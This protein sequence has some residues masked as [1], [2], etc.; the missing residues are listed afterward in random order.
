MSEIAPEKLWEHILCNLQ[1]QLQMVALEQA[2][3]V[4]NV[5]FVGAELHLETADRDA[6]EF[7]SADV[8]ARRIII[9]ARPLLEIFAVKVKLVEEE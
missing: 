4:S 5:S 7:F 1:D 3:R 9:L 2:Q 8:N 6:V